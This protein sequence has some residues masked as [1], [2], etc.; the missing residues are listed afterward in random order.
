M[1][2]LP[3]FIEANNLLRSEFIVTVLP[4]FIEIA[5]VVKLLSLSLS[6]FRDHLCHLAILCLDH[7]AHT[8]HHLESLLTISLD[9]LKEDL[10]YQSLRKSLS[11]CLSFLDSRI[12]MLRFPT[13]SVG[14]SNIDVLELPCL[15]VLI[16]GTA[17]S[18]QHGENRASW[19]DNLDDALW[20]FWTVYKALIGCT[21][22]KLV[23]EKACH[24]PVE[25]EH[26]AYWALKYANF[27]LNTASDLRK[28]QIIEL[29]ELRDQAYENSL[30]YKEKT[31]RLHDSKIKNR[32]FNIGDRVLLFNS[33]FKIFSGKLKSR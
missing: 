12:L 7:H 5:F 3:E 8:L 16:T 21:P 6:T 25:L 15:L 20:T 10:V 2:E 26:K 14:P 18:R 24:L 28:V 17:Q 19:L 23:Y 22:Y 11:S 27:D 33:R 32:V 29:N 9:I 13:Q 4:E 1:N 30:I 31:K